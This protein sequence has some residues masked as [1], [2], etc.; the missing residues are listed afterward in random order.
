M[1]YIDGIAKETGFLSEDLV[2]NF[3]SENGLTSVK[4]IV[5]QLGVDRIVTLSDNPNKQAKIQVKGR[6]QVSNPRWFQLVVS[7]KQLQE[8][9]SNGQ[10]LNQLWKNQID[11]VDFWILVS[12]PKD[13]IW[14]FPSKV[15]HEIAKA[16][17]L[18]YHTRRDNDYSNISYDHKGKVDRKQKEL[19]LDVCNEN[20]VPLYV[21][22]KEYK[23][24]AQLL[25]DF[26]NH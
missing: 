10:D 3:L 1:S 17:Y 5:R 2:D 26:L 8:A 24:N 19:N 7:S 21:K 23:N 22:Y 20:G 11:V 14:I 4:P 6:S 9:H 13:E 25:F 16:N 18:K 15:I 12:I